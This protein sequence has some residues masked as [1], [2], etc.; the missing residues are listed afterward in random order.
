MADAMP[1][2]DETLPVMTPAEAIKHLEEHIERSNGLLQKEPSPAEMDAYRETLRCILEDAFGGNSRWWDLI[3]RAGT[4]Y[5]VEEWEVTEYRHREI[6]EKNVLVAECIL[7]LRRREVRALATTGRVV[8]SLETLENILRQFHKVAT[9]LRKRHDGR[10]PV[11]LNDE[12]DVQDLLH[13]LLLVHFADVRPEEH[14]PSFA[15]ANPRLDFLLHDEQIVI[16]VKKTRSTHRDK[17]LADELIADIARYHS[18][19]RCKTLVCFV[20][21]PE[22]RISNVTGFIHDVQST[23]AKMAVRIL[24]VPQP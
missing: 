20:Y 18:H 15:G 12:Y 19:P 6:R 4:G 24:V 10:K 1:D 17:A 5:Y 8:S 9:Q 23:L 14:A 21:D 3:S 7:D 2:L 11:V 13:A 22:G 16:E